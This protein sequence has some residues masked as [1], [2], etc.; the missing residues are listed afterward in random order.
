M[1]ETMTTISRF[2]AFQERVALAD[3][4]LALDADPDYRRALFAEFDALLARRDAVLSLDIFDT[5]LLRDDSSELRR[6][7]EIGHAMAAVVGDHGDGVPVKVDAAD[8]F[9]LRCLGTQATYRAANR[10]DGCR[11]GCLSE[12]HRTAARMIAGAGSRLANTLHAAFVAA[13]LDHEARRLHPATAILDYAARHREGGRTV[14]LVTHT[15]MRESHVRAL[16]ARLDIPAD[17]FDLILS[18]ADTKVS[19]ASGGIFAL[20]ERALG[21]GPEAFVHA[22]DSL[23]GDYRRPIGHG[24]RAL[25]LPIALA[26]RRRRRADHIAISDE[27]RERHGFVP[28]VALPA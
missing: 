14:I 16:L 28:E 15:Y 12:I 9:L 22:G 10:I 23:D 24:W 8:A 7:W 6:F 19:K 20:A 25:H 26:E 27:I 3:S 21:R 17:A 2:G 13:E 18:S 4:R 1:A 11:E 5:L